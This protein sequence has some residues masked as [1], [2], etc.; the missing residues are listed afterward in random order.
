MVRGGSEKKSDR[1]R[2]QPVLNSVVSCITQ[3]AQLAAYLATTTRRWPKS[4]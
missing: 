4:A 1:R 2:F 3:L